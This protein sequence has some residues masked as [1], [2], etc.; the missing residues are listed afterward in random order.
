MLAPFIRAGGH[1]RATKVLVPTILGLVVS[2]ASFHAAP[3]SKTSPTIA[4]FLSAASPLEVV[5][6]TK[7]DRIAWV[8]YE[9]GRRNVYTAAAPAF[10]PVRLTNYMKD[11]GVDLTNVRISAD[12]STVV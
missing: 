11:D 3:Q 8:A 5:A 10:A 4:Q 9:Q 6:A 7:V 2:S 12:G 1:M